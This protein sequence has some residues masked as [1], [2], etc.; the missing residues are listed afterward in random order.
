[1][2]TSVAIAILSALAQESRLHIFRY[3]AQSG[4]QPAG[5]VGEHF[6]LPLATLSFHLKTLQQAG[7]L[8]CRREGRQLIYQARCTVIVELLGYLT[9]HCCN[10]PAM[11]A[12]HTD[13]SVVENER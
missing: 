2:E 6:G 13:G 12:D 8:D 4:P 1:M 9:E 10:L 7:L 5:Q 3:L 11:L